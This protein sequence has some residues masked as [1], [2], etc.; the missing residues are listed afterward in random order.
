MYLIDTSHTQL[1]GIVIFLACLGYNY[2][3]QTMLFNPESKRDFQK[4]IR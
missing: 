2:H 1:K 4:I 3:I